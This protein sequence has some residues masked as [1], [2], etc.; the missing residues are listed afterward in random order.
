MQRDPSLHA[1]QVAELRQMLSHMNKVPAP[2]NWVLCLVCSEDR[3]IEHY[4]QIKG[5]TRGQAIVQ[6]VW[7]LLICEDGIFTFLLFC[8]EAARQT[9]WVITACKWCHLYLLDSLFIELHCKVEFFE[10]S[11]FTGLQF[12][13]CVVIWVSQIQ[14]KLFGSYFIWKTL[15]HTLLAIN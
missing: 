3:V 9:V 12:S 14:N 15:L 1:E 13:I 11:N 4:T 8:W 2:L 6:W 5:L 10:I 7:H